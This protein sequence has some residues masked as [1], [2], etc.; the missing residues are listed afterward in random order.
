MLFIP[1]VLLADIYHHIMRLTLP[2]SPEFYL[3]LFCGRFYLY[4]HKYRMTVGSHAV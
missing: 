1:R 3:F 2:L 4:F